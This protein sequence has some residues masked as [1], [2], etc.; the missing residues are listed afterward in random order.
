MP[1]TTTIKPSGTDQ[2]PLFNALNAA[3]SP[4]D[5][6]RLVKYRL[7]LD[8]DSVFPPNSL[9]KD[10]V[11]K[12]LEEV[13][14]TDR[15]YDFLFLVCLDKPTNLVLLEICGQ[16]RST[17]L[18]EWQKLVRIRLL[19]ESLR[20]GFGASVLEDLVLKLQKPIPATVPKTPLEKLAFGLA[21][22]ADQENLS[23]S[24]VLLALH[25]CPN[26][27]GLQEYTRF[28]LSLPPP[29]SPADPAPFVG[30]KESDSV[31][32][33]LEALR[34]L[35]QAHPT[36]KARIDA[37]RPRLEEIEDRS[38][39]LSSLKDLHESLHQLLTEY[40][41]KLRLLALEAATPIARRELSKL[42][43]RFKSEFIQRFKSFVSDRHLSAD[44]FEWIQELEE[45]DKVWAKHLNANGAQP[46]E[47]ILDDIHDSIER[48]AQ[49]E[50][51]KLN[52][53]MVEGAREFRISQ[54]IQT[55]DEIS[56]ALTDTMPPSADLVPIRKGFHDLADLNIQ[57]QRLIDEHDHWQTIVHELEVFPV[58]NVRQA[59]LSWKVIITM[60]QTIIPLSPPEWMSDYQLY[61]TGLE[62]A[63]TLG[64]V[65]GVEEYYG[66]VRALIEARFVQVDKALDD[67]FDPLCEAGRS[68]SFL[69]T[70]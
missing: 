59:R 57:L 41:P 8:P 15:W 29:Q 36:I 48:V 11:N 63:L 31:K 66:N 51:Y 16:L 20:V 14:R 30:K 44:H 42:R 21:E 52:V 13:D 23:E 33:T 22:W 39:R 67:F 45:V 43:L 50:S 25:F 54:L 6:Q 38:N 26:H 4:D 37:C 60:G 62:T 58:G 3:F 1:T 28:F 65:A 32:A 12:L 24:L 46:D 10:W 68:L 53:R 17:S 35:A 55:L 69:L 64:N 18:I 19:G 40:P 27:P 70:V 47:S 56:Q 7:N 2:L 49:R 9:K 5:L 61:A 34:H